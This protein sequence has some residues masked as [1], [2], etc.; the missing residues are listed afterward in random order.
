MLQDRGQ[1]IRWEVV[2]QHEA[3]SD[4]VGAHRL[5]GPPLRDTGVLD[6]VRVGDEPAQRRG[7]QGHAGLGESAPAS[8]RRSDIRVG[9][10]PGP[11]Q[12]IAAARTGLERRV[13]RHGTG[14][15]RGGA[16]TRSTRDGYLEGMD[17]IASFIQGMPKAELHL[18]IEGTLEPEL[19]LEL[20][21]R[22]GVTLP[23]GS[24]EALRSA[25]DFHDLTSFLVGYYEG[26][27]VLVSEPASSS[28]PSS[29]AC[30]A[31]SWKPRRPSASGPS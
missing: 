26:M 14:R 16:A 5:D 2:L 3:E 17:D 25:Y 20:A 18:H 12:C 27:S 7:R 28:R 13:G 23:Y 8:D 21:A 1:T 31:P 10:A 22:N 29:R 15:I 9:R 19:K 30:T 24:I 6:H 4:A 11:R